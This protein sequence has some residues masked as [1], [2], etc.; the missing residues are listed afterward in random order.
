MYLDEIAFKSKIIFHC[1]YHEFQDMLM[2]QRGPA[3]IKY[4]H[5]AS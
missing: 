2:S 1:C 4:Q 5:K 3:V